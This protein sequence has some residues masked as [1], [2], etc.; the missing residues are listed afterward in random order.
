MSHQ[1]SLSLELILLLDWFLKHGKKQLRSLVKE[2]AKKNLANELED[3][4]DRDYVRMLDGLQNTVAD[5]VVFLE[6]SLLDS[7][8]E[9]DADV[10]AW[11]AQDAMEPIIKVLDNNVLDPKTLWLSIQQTRKNRTLHEHEV[12]R[13]FFRQILKNWKPPSSESVN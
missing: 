2:A 12:K 13:E 7:L 5:F 4:S 8:D 6:D 3:I 11:C 9:V 10:C 1:L